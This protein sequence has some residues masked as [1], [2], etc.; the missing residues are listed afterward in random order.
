MLHALM[1]LTYDTCVNDNIGTCIPSTEMPQVAEVF[2]MQCNGHVVTNVW[3]RKT[4]IIMDYYL[5]RTF[6]RLT[7]GGVY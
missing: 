2:A 6:S 5:R 4:I 7:L 3:E 1:T